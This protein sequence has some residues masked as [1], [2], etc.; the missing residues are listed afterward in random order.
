MPLTSAARRP[1]SSSPTRRAEQDDLPDAERGGRQLREPRARQV[2]AGGLAEGGRG[3]VVNQRR[4]AAGSLI[5]TIRLDVAAVFG[6]KGRL[7]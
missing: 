4:V 1:G 3:R 7:T 2:A 6:L 5:A